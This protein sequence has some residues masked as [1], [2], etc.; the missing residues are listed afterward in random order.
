MALHIFQ[1][2][3]Q[4]IAE[5]VHPVMAHEAGDVRQPFRRG[6]QAVGLLIL[7]HL[8]PVLQHAQGA[9]VARQLVGG[10]LSHPAFPGQRGQRPLRGGH[11]QRRMAPAQDQLLG[12]GEEFDLAN[13]AAPQLDIVPGHLDVAMT[14]VSVD[15]PLDGMDVLDGGEVQIAPPDKG[16]DGLQ[17]LRA[18][19][20]IAGAGAR[21]DHG[22]AFPVLAHA[23]IVIERRIGGDG[24]LG[25][26]R[27]G[28][29]PEV[30]AKDIAVGR[31]FGQQPHQPAHDI[32]GRPAHVTA[33][34]KRESPGVI[35]D[36]QVYV[37]GI[38]QL[39]G[40][41][42]AHR[43]HGQPAVLFRHL[44]P[45]G[46]G[47][48][49]PQ[50]EA[51]RRAHTGIGEAGQLGGDLVY[52]PRPGNVGH[53]D[54]Q[55]RAPPRHPQQR[56]GFGFVLRPRRAVGVLDRGIQHRQRPRRQ[57]F[58]QRAVLTHRQAAKEG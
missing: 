10:L 8:Q 20:R 39:M 22:G 48:R 17:E 35:K 43:Q 16:R 40:T 26:P 11:T 41:E 9:V 18:G 29:K 31:D 28:A 23:L 5:I 4:R 38:V 19:R 27:I 55:R 2:R 34:G 57:I 51:Q 49:L 58:G 30:D 56:H 32:D 25:R 54:G 44:V 24:D 36:D 15:L 12:L 42:F 1:R 47:G 46:H 6:G 13:T 53:G 45:A 50:H 14:G 21:L 7:H 3:G 52:I 37:A 33:L